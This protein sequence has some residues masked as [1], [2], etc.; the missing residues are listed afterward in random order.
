[1]RPLILAAFAASLIGGGVA[2]I[3]AQAACRPAPG[4]W[5]CVRHPPVHNRVVIHKTIVHPAPVPAPPPVVV[6]KTIVH[7]Q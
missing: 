3:P 5:A 4:G 2:A 7:R 1:M 6:H